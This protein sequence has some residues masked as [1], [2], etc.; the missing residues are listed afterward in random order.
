L[1]GEIIYNL[2]AAL[3]YLVYELACFDSHQIVE[4]TQFPIDSKESGFLHR[5]KQN[6]ALSEKGIYLRGVSIAHVTLFQQ[7]QPCYG[8]QWTAILAALSD[9]DKHREL[10]VVNTP[11]S[12]TPE[13]GTEQF[14][15]DGSVYLH[16]KATRQVAFYDGAPVIQR[17]QYLQF[18]VSQVI[19]EFY[20][21]FQ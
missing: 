5:G 14:L 9:P 7:Y 20:P 12:L 15:P 6:P 11:F 2:R 4:G 21:Q 13:S 19:D 18:Q 10:I 16:Y 8:C 1:V 17:L 3:D